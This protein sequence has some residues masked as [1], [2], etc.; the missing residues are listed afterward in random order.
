M[1]HGKPISLTSFDLSR[2]G[3]RC[4]EVL[5]DDGTARLMLLPADCGIEQLSNDLATELDFRS[6][7]A[8]SIRMAQITLPFGTMR[9]GMQLSEGTVPDFVAT[10]MDGSRRLGVHVLA[11]PAGLDQPFVDRLLASVDAL[12]RLLIVCPGTS[13][14]GSA[15]THG[16]ASMQPPVEIFHGDGAG[17]LAVQLARHLYLRLSDPIRVDPIPPIRFRPRA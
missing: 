7:L 12:E 9:A 17:S 16:L 10:N 6:E 5:C 2:P 14:Y 4:A 13:S 11:R 15:E 8:K 1:E 3:W